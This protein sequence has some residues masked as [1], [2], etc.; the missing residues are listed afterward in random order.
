MT[1]PVDTALTAL[2][3]QAERDKFAMPGVPPSPENAYLSMVTLR[4]R[5]R[6]ARTTYGGA[7]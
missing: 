3:E 1:S 7:S 5:V 4:T 2:L 6:E